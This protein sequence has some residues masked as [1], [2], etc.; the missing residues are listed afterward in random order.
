MEASDR[1]PPGVFFVA[2]GV[3]EP[4]PVAPGVLGSQRVTR[5]HPLAGRADAAGGGATECVRLP[6]FDDADVVPGDGLLAENAVPGV[7]EGVPA[8]LVVELA[9]KPQSLF[10]VSCKLVLHEP[11]FAYAPAGGREEYGL[12]QEAGAGLWELAASLPARAAPDTA[13]ACP[14]SLIA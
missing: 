7:V 6:L 14:G 9:Q 4:D 13:S 8:S 11:S 3:E 12:F 10:G 5:V 2:Q 1:P